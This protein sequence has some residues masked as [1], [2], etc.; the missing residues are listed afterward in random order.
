MFFILS[1]TLHVFAQPIIWMAGGL[2]FAL[3]TK[4][5]KRRKKALLI[6]VS[7]FL[8]FTNDYLG[9][10]MFKWWEVEPTSISSVA[11]ASYGVILSGVTNA[12]IQPQDRVYFNKGADRVTQAIQLFKLGKIDTLIVTGGSGSLLGNEKNKSTEAEKIAF[13]MEYCGVPRTQIILD[14]DAKNTNQNAINT[15]QLVGDASCLLI[16]SAF[17]MRRAS[18][19]FEKREINFIPFPVDYYTHQ[20]EF[21]FQNIIPSAAAIP[22]WTKLIKEW[23]GYT[24]YSLVGYV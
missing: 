24:M 16:T 2:L 6:T 15:A 5:Q 13:V 7:L 8:F 17:H 1:K 19:C 12:E 14:N 11:H 10:K 23:I 21:G 20:D 22:A 9:N 4:N 3:V 18:A